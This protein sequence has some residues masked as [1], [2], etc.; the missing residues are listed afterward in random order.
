MYKVLIT[1]ALTGTLEAIEPIF[2]TMKNSTKDLFEGIVGLYEEHM[3][4]LIDSIF[5]GISDEERTVLK[6]SNELG[7]SVIRGFEKN[8]FNL[9]KKVNVSSSILPDLS[10]LINQLLPQ[11]SISGGDIIIQI[12]DT[13]FARFA[14]SKINEEQERAGMTLLKI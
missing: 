7:V 8:D 3:K 14:I 11:K 1:D 6:E 5:K 12:G 4:P 10:E 13:E 9:S 2:E